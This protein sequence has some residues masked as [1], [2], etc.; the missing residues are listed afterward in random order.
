MSDPIGAEEFPCQYTFKVF[1]RASDTLVERVSGIIAA[2]L[3]PLPADAVRVRE[4][5]QGRYLSVTVDVRVDSRSQ[6][7][8]VY[9]DLRAES[10]VL[11]YI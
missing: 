2:T 11:L 7:E 1:G 10:E 5:R 6:L 9:T 3:G 4:S 8:Q